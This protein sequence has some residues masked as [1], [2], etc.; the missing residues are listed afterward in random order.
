MAPAPRTTVASSRA[1]LW[2][3][4]QADAG[5]F[6]TERALQLPGSS[7]PIEPVKQEWQA[8]SDSRC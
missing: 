2:E 3:G 5:E 4:Q 7:G 8:S 1:G 6:D